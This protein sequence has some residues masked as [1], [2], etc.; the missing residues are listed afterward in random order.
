MDNVRPI[1]ASTFFTYNHPADYTP[2]WKT[3]YDNALNK[4]VR[5]QAAFNHELNLKY[6]EYPHQIVN[7]YYPDKTSEQGAPVIIYFHGGRWRE[8]HPAFYDHLATPWVQAGAIFMSC[9]YRLE[10]THSLADAVDDA[11][12]VVDWAAEYCSHYGGD[13]RRIF[14]SGHSSGGHLAAM[15]SLTDW[16]QER[17][18]AYPHGLICMSGPLNLADRLDTDEAITRLSPVNRVSR[19]PEHII[20]SYGDPEP[21]KVGEDEYKLTNDGELLAETLV[22]AGANPTVV[23]FGNMDHL[24]TATAFSDTTSKLFKAAYSAIFEQAN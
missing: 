17:R 9:G 2:D 10:P 12:T 1:D 6:G 16:G 8:G 5:T 19:F 3:F 11:V 24:K 23:S 4:R 21:N 20:I 14:I 18:H 22:S 15:A 7:I 13:P